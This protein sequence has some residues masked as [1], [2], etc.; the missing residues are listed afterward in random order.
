V[1]AERADRLTLVCSANRGDAAKHLIDDLLTHAPVEDAGR[2]G[3]DLLAIFYTGGTTGRSK[4]VMLSH[5]GFVGNC[6]TMR[7]VGLFPAGCRAL[8]VAPLFHLAAAAAMT[9]A[10]LAGGTAVIARAFDP[11]GTLDL[12]ARSR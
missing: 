10:M 2:C 9:M 3:D 4:G 1:L 5:A 12:I 6:Q 7:D 8:I 11:A